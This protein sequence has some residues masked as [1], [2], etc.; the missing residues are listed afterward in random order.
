MS[1]IYAK[2]LLDGINNPDNIDNRI[3]PR[4]VDNFIYRHLVVMYK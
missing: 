4:Q 3:K 2:K 1:G